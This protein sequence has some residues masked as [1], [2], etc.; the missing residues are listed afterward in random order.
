MGHTEDCMIR[1]IA[2]V[3]SLLLVVPACPPSPQ[4][5]APVGDAGGTLCS[6]ACANLAGLDCP[7][8]RAPNCATT[9][10]H[11]QVERLTDLHPACLAL[12][13]TKAEARACKSVSCP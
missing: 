7:E 6:V 12:A 5:P 11:A 4:P 13:K 1:S 3:A 2:L 8:G 10:E 9:C